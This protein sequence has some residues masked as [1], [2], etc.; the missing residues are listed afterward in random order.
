MFSEIQSNCGLQEHASFFHMTIRKQ[1]VKACVLWMNDGRIYWNMKIAQDDSAV[2][3][4]CNDWCGL[5]LNVSERI[6]EQALNCSLEGRQMKF[7]RLTR[8][9][10]T[11]IAMM[12]WPRWTSAWHRQIWVLTV[13]PV[14]LYFSSFVVYS[15]FFFLNTKPRNYIH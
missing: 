7:P 14:W 13:M 6:S 10:S 3:L 15:S 5:P 4:G 9:L 11:E 8:L 12:S 1:S 2:K